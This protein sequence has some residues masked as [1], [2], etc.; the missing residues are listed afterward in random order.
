MT[1]MIFEQQKKPRLV[2]DIQCQPRLGS[3]ELD[4]SAPQ[5]YQRYASCVKL[6]LTYPAI[7]NM[8]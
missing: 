2:A 6:D 8:N 7:L 3:F 1:R 5:L 4:L